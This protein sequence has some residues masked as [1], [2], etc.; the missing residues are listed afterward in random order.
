MR[1][2]VAVLGDWDSDGPIHVELVA[3]GIEDASIKRTTAAGLE[4]IS[5][6]LA[7]CPL[8]STGCMGPG[9]PVSIEVES[10]GGSLNL[11]LRIGAVIVS[12]V[13]RADP[14]RIGDNAAVTV[15]EHVE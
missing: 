13:V 8:L 2:V 9:G 11:S 15:N 4:V 12:F 6:A 14:E 3:C 1:D 10:S 5:T 7:S